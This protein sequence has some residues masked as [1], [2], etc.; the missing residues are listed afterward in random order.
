MPPGFVDF[1]NF[2][3]GFGFTGREA[4]SE[5]REFSKTHQVGFC[6]GCHTGVVLLTHFLS[7]PNAAWSPYRCNDH[8]Y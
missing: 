2:A 1:P 5:V 8:K 7:C 3:Q 6:Q 4:I